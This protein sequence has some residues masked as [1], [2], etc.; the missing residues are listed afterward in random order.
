MGFRSFFQSGNCYSGEVVPNDR[1]S[2]SPSPLFLFNF[3]SFFL[4]CLI[5]FI[6]KDL[7]GHDD[8]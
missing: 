7:Y 1:I 8:L 2:Q 4:F 5:G 6:I 3:V